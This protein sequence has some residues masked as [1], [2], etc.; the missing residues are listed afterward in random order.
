MQ[1]VRVSDGAVVVPC[2][3]SSAEIFSVALEVLVLF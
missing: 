1:A 3:A 2:S